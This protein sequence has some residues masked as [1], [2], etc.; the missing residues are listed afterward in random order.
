LIWNKNRVTGSMSLP[1]LSDGSHRLS[2]YVEADAGTGKSYWDSETVYFTVETTPPKIKVLS[3]LNQTYTETS[4]SLAFKLDK[5]ANWTSY[6]IDNEGNVT[7]TG[8][9]SLKGLL[10][11]LHNLTVYANDTYGNMGASETI[12]FTVAVPEP[13]PFVPVAVA[14]ATTTTVVAIGVLVYFKKRKH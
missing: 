10:N 3:P 7:V 8:N 9:V 13:F 14:S 6:S 1:E 4:V 11:G 5:Q 12:S 2:V